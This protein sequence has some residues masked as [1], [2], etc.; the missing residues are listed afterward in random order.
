MA[1]IQSTWTTK[2]SGFITGG[3]E[4]TISHGNCTMSR[5]Q[6]LTFIGLQIRFHDQRQVVWVL[7]GLHKRGWVHLCGTPSLP[8]VEMMDQEPVE[9]PQYKIDLKAAQT[10]L[11]C[12]L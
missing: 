7:R 4:E 11:G 6:E 1:F 8:Q 2:F 5:V 3:N 9:Y 12:L 10:E